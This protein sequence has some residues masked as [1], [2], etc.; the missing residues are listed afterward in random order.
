M[1]PFNGEPQ[2]V[3]AFVIRNTFP[4]FEVCKFQ[5][6]QDIR[7]TNKAGFFLQVTSTRA[8]NLAAFFKPDCGKYLNN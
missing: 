8:I 3:H 4:L 7:R 1:D 2:A 5:G 6:E